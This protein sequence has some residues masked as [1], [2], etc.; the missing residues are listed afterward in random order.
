MLSLSHCAKC[1]ASRFDLGIPSLGGSEDLGVSSL[2]LL[3]IPPIKDMIASFF[4]FV[5]V[6]INKKISSWCF[7]PSPNSAS[8]QVF[9][10]FL[11]YWR[12]QETYVV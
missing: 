6:F 2:W 8:L 9:L 5:F 7:L 10:S 3:I 12:K 1:S 4:G 11:S